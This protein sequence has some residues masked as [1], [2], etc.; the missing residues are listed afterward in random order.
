VTEFR[1]GLGQKIKG[2]KLTACHGR[3]LGG[4]GISGEGGRLEERER[5]LIK[6]DESEKIWARNTVERS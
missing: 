6:S 2:Y 4:G 1:R 5:Q 3:T